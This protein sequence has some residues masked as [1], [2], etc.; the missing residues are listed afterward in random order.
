LRQETID[1]FGKRIRTAGTRGRLIIKQCFP[2]VGGLLLLALAVPSIGGNN[3]A[4][5]EQLD[6]RHG[7]SHVVGVIGL[8]LALIAIAI[9]IAVPLGF[10]WA[11]ASL[12]A[13]LPTGRRA[14]GIAAFVLCVGAAFVTFVL[15]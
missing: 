9:V 10:L 7:F 6:S 8:V 2:V 15:P 14:L 3:P 4:A 5:L 12:L 13:M 1:A 11:I